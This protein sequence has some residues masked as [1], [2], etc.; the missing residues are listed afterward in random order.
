[1]STEVLEE[2]AWKLP[3]SHYDFL[4]L[5]DQEKS[6]NKW[7]KNGGSRSG[8]EY[9]SVSYEDGQ[10]LN[11]GNDYLSSDND[12]RTTLLEMRNSRLYTAGSTFQSSEGVADGSASA[13]K[14]ILH[15]EL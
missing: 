13:E 14:V 5:M 6:S 8:S 12:I 15:T 1:M 11:Q 7:N 9:G 10:T 3:R 2:G 4:A